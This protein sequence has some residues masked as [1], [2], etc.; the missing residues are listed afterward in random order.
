MFKMT[1][2]YEDDLDPWKRY[3]EETE[4]SFDTF[5]IEEPP[6]LEDVDCG[7]TVGSYNGGVLRLVTATTAASSRMLF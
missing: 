2:P 1:C 7:L 4:E 5:E 3:E 6:R